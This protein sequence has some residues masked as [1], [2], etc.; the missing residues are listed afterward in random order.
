MHASQAGQCSHTGQAGLRDPW[1]QAA[2]RQERCRAWASLVVRVRRSALPLRL[3]DRAKAWLSPRVTPFTRPRKR[4]SSIP[5]PGT[6]SSGP[7]DS[8]MPKR[9]SAVRSRSDRSRRRRRDEEAN[10][11]RR[12]LLYVQT[13]AQA[14]AA[15]AAD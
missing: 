7:E 12:A 5:I 1:Y 15:V 11:F 4:V 6:S 3:S 10:R 14:A 9:K 8:A 13:A 2:Q